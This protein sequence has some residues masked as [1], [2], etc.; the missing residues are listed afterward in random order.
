MPC[1][2]A[3]KY[4]CDVAADKEEDA[5]ERERGGQREGAWVTRV[6]SAC[7]ESESPI[8]ANTEENGMSRRMTYTDNT[9]RAEPRWGF[10]YARA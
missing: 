9:L 2:V 8:R 7:V 10:T 6:L 5:R 3:A 4:N 1:T